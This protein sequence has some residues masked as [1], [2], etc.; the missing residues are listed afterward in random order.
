LHPPTSNDPCR[1]HK[2]EEEEEE[3]DDDDDDDDDDGAVY[4]IGLG[5]SRQ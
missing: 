5:A 2:E 4:L 3:E 1:T